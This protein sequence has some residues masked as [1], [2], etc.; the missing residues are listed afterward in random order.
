MQ[1]LSF[2]T[3][4]FEDKGDVIK[5]ILLKLYEVDIPRVVLEQIAPFKV[6]LREISFETDNADRAVLFYRVL[7]D[8]FNDLKNRV[9]GKRV[10]YIHRGSGVP[11]IGNIA[12]GIAYRGTNIVE[13]K[14]MTGCNIKCNYCSVNED[15]RL[16]DVVVEKDYL[17]DEFKKL[18]LQMGCDDVEV[19]VGPQ[20]EPLLYGDLVELVRDLKA[21]PQVKRISMVTNGTLLTTQMMD[22]LIR[23]GL[24]RVDLSINAVD[25]KTAKE[26]AGVGDAYNIEKIK[27]VAGYLCDKVELII[28][29]TWIPGFNDDQLEALV[30]FAKSLWNARFQPKVG[31]QNFLEYRYGRN[32]AKQASWERFYGMLGDL[33]KKQGVKLVMDARDFKIVPTR[34]LKK[35]F[36]KGDV[37]DVNIVMQGRLPK[38]WI[39]VAEDRNISVYGCEGLGKQSVK[40]TSSKHNIF[41]AVCV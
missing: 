33:E 24:T 2:E 7:A 22:S 28:T 5:V 25:S 39:G 8:A 23:A 4:L 9:S 20:G 40:I 1:T 26:I 34:P 18:V 14:P 21:I 15:A 29:P 10:V 37:V 27:N 16:I 13:V 36:G 35:P 11:L 6:G 32:P 3:L 30:V 17:V 38:E 19:H 41:T 31:I 12:F